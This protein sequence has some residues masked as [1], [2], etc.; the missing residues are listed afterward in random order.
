MSQSSSDIPEVNE[1]EAIEFGTERPIDMSDVRWDDNIEPVE[2]FFDQISDAVQRFGSTTRKLRQ[3][4][5]S[6]MSDEQ[7]AEVV[8]STAPNG[9]EPVGRDQMRMF[10][11]DVAEARKATKPIIVYA[12]AAA[13]SFVLY[14][15]IANDETDL[16]EN[17]EAI[18]ESYATYYNLA[19]DETQTPAAQY[20]AAC[21]I[22]I[23]EKQ[24]DVCEVEKELLL[25]LKFFLGVDANN[26]VELLQYMQSEDFSPDEYEPFMRFLANNFFDPRAEDVIGNQLE[27]AQERPEYYVPAFCSMMDRCFSEDDETRANNIAMVGEENLSWITFLKNH[28]TSNDTTV[29]NAFNAISFEDWPQSLQDRLIQTHTDLVKALEGSY[30]E[31]LRPH[32]DAK[33]YTVASEELKV[34]MDN[35]ITR[36]NG[37]ETSSSKSRRKK[38]G[39]ASIKNRPD[40]YIP[41]AAEDLPVIT[42]INVLAQGPRGYTLTNEYDTTGQDTDAVKEIIKELPPVKAY[43]KARL[44]LTLEK[45]IMA[46]FESLLK[47][48]YG[49][50]ASKM[51]AWK[52]KL[53]LGERQ[54]KSLP[55]WHLNPNKRTNM[56]IGDVGR[57]TRLYYVP[58]RNSDGIFCIALLDV[59]HK[60]E[61]AK[62]T[63]S[64][65]GGN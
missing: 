26:I 46:M 40:A 42:N 12:R 3:T 50:G 58:Y 35:G 61:M 43:L 51:H 49:N 5:T 6:A 10:K 2:A 48:P 4:C 1:V 16:S 27:T 15:L 30:K 37:N 11:R 45:D 54:S 8:L 47:E 32:T 29:G 57:D 14:E 52:V 60:N 33:S 36:A 20:G 38:N 23:Y 13:Q 17:R 22:D 34:M 21:W 28:Y 62:H 55:V 44:D 63:S 25:A 53:V 7:L 24:K 64:G 31:L 65:R 41:E 19:K 59:G 18:K 56:S 9:E 39:R